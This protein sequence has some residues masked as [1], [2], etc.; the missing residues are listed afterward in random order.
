[1]GE[2]QRRGQGDDHQRGIDQ[3]HGGA[4]LGHKGMPQPHDQQRQ[5]G[6]AQEGPVQLGIAQDQ[7]H[8]K[9]RRQQ[10]AHD[11]LQAHKRALPGRAR[12]MLG[13]HLKPAARGAA[14]L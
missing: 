4:R 9:Q 6:Q 1:M 11:H 3:R 12:L 13:R 8:H 14:M 7:R 10:Q 5:R 2:P